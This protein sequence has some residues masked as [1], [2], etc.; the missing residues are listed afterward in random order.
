MNFIEAIKNPAELRGLAPNAKQR[1]ELEIPTWLI[2]LVI[3]L[4]VGVVGWMF[5]S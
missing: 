5:I 3:L 1:K 2:I 4:F